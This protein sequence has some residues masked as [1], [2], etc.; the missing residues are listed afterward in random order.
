MSEQAIQITDEVLKR[1]EHISDH[2]IET[3]I[4]DTQGEIDDLRQRQKAYDDLATSGPGHERRLYAFKRDAIPNMIA[5]RSI[6]IRKL[7]ALLS[8]HQGVGKEQQ[9]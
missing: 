4:A 5:E 7:Q 1:N 8:A 2:E 3:D 9:P 6:F